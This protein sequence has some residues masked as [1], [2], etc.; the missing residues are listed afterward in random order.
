MTTTATVRFDHDR[1]EPQTDALIVAVASFHS[2][3][4]NE[5]EVNMKMPPPPPRTP[6]PKVVSLEDVRLERYGIVEDKAPYIIPR[7]ADWLSKVV[8]PF[9][10]AK[11]GD[12]VE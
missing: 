4:S 2:D 9:R 5:Y 6:R 7:S 12:L 1:W 3:G 11:K 10:A 8:V